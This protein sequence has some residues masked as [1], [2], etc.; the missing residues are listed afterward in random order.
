MAHPT[1][2]GSMDDYGMPLG[3]KQRSISGERYLLTGD[4]TFL[5]APFTGEGVGNALYSGYIA[6]N[7]AAKSLQTNDFS[8]KALAAYDKEVNR[9]MGPELRM[10]HRL[11]RL[12]HYPR[13]VNLLVKISIRNKQLK[14]LLSCK[15]FGAELRKKLA[16]PSF[17]FKLLLNR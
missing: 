8:A 17:Y 16:T 5:I 2:S 14:E 13:L 4:A 9:V 10:S 6:A 12:I 1:T 11:Q 3:G 7:Q 15:F